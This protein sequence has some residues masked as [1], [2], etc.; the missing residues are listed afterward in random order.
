MTT[1]Q[2]A[3]RGLTNDDLWRIKSTTDARL[4]PD[5]TRVVYTVSWMKE[6]DDSLHSSLWIMD[7]DGSNARQ[8]TSGEAADMQP[9][10]SPDGTRLAFVS[11]RAGAPQ[12]FVL[13]FGG[14]DPR[15]LTSV[16]RGA[17]SPM[18]S[19]DGT[20][21][22]YSSN[23]EGESHLVESEKTWL[24]AHPQVAEKKGPKLRKLT[25]LKYRF[26]SLGYIEG[27]NHL[28]LINAEGGEPRQLTDGPWDESGAA[29]S[30]DGK[31]IAFLSDRSE[32]AERYWSTAVWSV[33]VESGEARRLTS[34]KL[35][36]FTGGLSWS[37][38]SSTLAFYASPD[39]AREAFA[40]P[41]LWL[42]SRQGGDARDL[43]GVL[44]L[45]AS[46]YAGTDFSFAMPVAPPWSKDGSTIYPTLGDHGN[47]VVYA[48]DV[49]TQST[50]RIS[51]GDGGPGGVQL[52]PDEKTLLC[53]AATP[54]RPLEVG[55]IPVAGGPFTP[56]TD[57]NHDL[58]AEVS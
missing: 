26:D 32:D 42:V 34:D 24:E 54:T 35:G 56:L 23:V 48:I 20:K 1:E 33:D 2:T 57:V 36:A 46:H 17:S 10:W 15:K 38:D 58:L 55:T 44:D 29:W 39:I 19:P 8:L 18:W 52:T 28:F 16:E 3:R 22:V 4:S 50:R 27:R 6:E 45:P 47:H 14:G 40:E 53:I 30:P 31:E 37:P 21:I 5:G 12:V 49:K 9:A 13:D 41:H 11:T 43:S 7:L 51:T 25:A